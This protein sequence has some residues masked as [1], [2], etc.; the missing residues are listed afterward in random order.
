M[1]R[2]HAQVNVG[3]WNDP[4]FRALPPPAQHLYFVLWT[5]PNLSYCGV[6]DWRPGRIAT[7]A[8]NWTEASFANA[9]DCLRARHF[10]VIDTDSEEC[11][12]RSWVRWDGLM[13]QPRLAISYVKA[14]T[15]VSSNLLRGVIVDEL[16]RLQEREPSFSCWTDR[17][18]T[19]LLEHPRISAKSEVSVQDPFGDRSRPLLTQTLVNAQGSVQPPP[20]PA[21]TPTPNSDQVSSKRVSRPRGASATADGDFDKFWNLYPKKINKQATM[22]KWTTVI[23]STA[24]SDVIDGLDRSVKHWQRQKTE[25]HFIPAPDTWLNKGCWEDEF[26]E[27]EAPRTGLKSTP[28]EREHFTPPPAPSDTPG[29]LVVQWNLAWSRAAREGRPGPTDWRELEAS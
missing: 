9:A 24:A 27:M 11:L 5:D 17:R 1:A 23:R 26:D 16:H 6:V 8:A 3:L 19:D 28:I 20:T 29:R 25:R 15:T 4:E 22:R 21:P 13:R 14:F 18:V 2:D 10:I 12:V 7:K